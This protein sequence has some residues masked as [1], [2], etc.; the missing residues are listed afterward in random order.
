[1]THPVIFTRK[2]L[3]NF[4]LT[5]NTPDDAKGKKLRSHLMGK[6]DGTGL[7]FRHSNVTDAANPECSF[8]TDDPQVQAYIR[9]IAKANPQLQIKEDLTLMPVR[10]PYCE[11]VTEDNSAASQQALAEH[12]AD[13]HTPE[14]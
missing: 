9:K 11:Y 5:I 7:H 12:I 10:C 6:A 2:G 3:V 8:T 14:D 13:S 1:M 4:V